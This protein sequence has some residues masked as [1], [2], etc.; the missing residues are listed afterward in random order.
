MMMQDTQQMITDQKKMN[1]MLTDIM[2]MDSSLKT[3]IYEYLSVE[4]CIFYFTDL[5][6][7]AK[8]YYQLI[9]TFQLIL[10]K[11]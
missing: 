8:D 10:T 5:L 1:V 11:V 9:V 2:M 6:I 7:K 4:L 3:L